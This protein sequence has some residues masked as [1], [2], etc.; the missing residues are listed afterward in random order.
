MAKNE[1]PR[2][3]FLSISQDATLIK[4]I[5]IRLETTN[6]KIMSKTTIDMK[7]LLT[8]TQETQSIYTRITTDR[9]L[10]Q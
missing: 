8:H 6:T 9:K 5:P 3:V 1:H 2:G 4:A 7:R 10:T